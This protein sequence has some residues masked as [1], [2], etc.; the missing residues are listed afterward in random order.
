MAG[1]PRGAG[2]VARGN[3]GPVELRRRPYRRPE[4]AWSAANYSCCFLMV[5]DETFY[6]RRAAAG[7]RWTLSWT[8]ASGSS[9]ATTASCCGTPT[10]GSGWTSATSSISTATC[11]AA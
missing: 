8:T 10:R 9:A 3:A 6:D 2:P 5:C 4:F 11:P 1:V 7:T